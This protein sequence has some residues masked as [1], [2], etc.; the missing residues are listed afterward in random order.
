ML[1]ILFPYIESDKMLLKLISLCFGFAVWLLGD[2]KF[3]KWLTF[4]TCI[5]FLGDRTPLDTSPG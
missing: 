1:E 2:S 5:L 3:T 4:V